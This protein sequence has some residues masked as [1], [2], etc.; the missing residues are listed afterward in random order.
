MTN[1]NDLLH[2]WLP[3]AVAVTPKNYW[4]ARAWKLLERAELVTDGQLTTTPAKARSDREKLDEY[5]MIAE[6]MLRATVDLLDGGEFDDAIIGIPFARNAESLAK[7]VSERACKG[8]GLIPA[9]SREIELV[10]DVLVRL[11]LE[12]GKKRGAS[13]QP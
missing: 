10:A 12:N 3:V 7:E 6:A 4:R 11:V 8:R 13:D 1:G 9:E 5:L 2:R